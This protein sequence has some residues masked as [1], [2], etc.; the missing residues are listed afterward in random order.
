LREKGRMIELK[1][2]EEEKGSEARGTTGFSLLLEVL[3]DQFSFP[4]R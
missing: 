1:A 3:L 4:D 2:G